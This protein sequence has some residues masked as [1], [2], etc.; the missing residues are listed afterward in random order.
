MTTKGATT[1]T[2]TTSEQ[3]AVSAGTYV[4]GDIKVAAAQVSED[5]TAV[6][7]AQEQLINE[8]EAEL[9]G[10]AS[11]G[12]GAVETC[13]VRVGLVAATSKN[14]SFTY[15]QNG[16]LVTESRPPTDGVAVY[17]EVFNVD[18]NTIFCITNVLLFGPDVED[19]ATITNGSFLIKTA[20]YVTFTVESN[21]VTMQ[22]G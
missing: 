6:L 20:G 5:L 18:K 15:T 2:P 3:V 22:I 13:T 12:G 1:I 21:N 17:D 4:T 8:L 14:A 9:E 7:N 10:K 19:Y 11:G 16:T